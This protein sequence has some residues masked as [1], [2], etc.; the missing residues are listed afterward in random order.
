MLEKMFYLQKYD[1]NYKGKD[2]FVD[3]NPYREIDADITADPRVETMTRNIEMYYYNKACSN[4][5]SSSRAEDK[6]DI[7]GNETKYQI[8]DLCPHVFGEENL[9]ND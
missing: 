2:M 7:N 5:Y 8:K 3:I 6:Y 1:D 4:Y 9:K